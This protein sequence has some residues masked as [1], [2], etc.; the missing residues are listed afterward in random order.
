MPWVKQFD[1]D[2]ALNRAMEAFWAN[3]YEATSL[4]TL[5]RRMNINKGSFYDTYGDKRSLFLAALRS[6][7]VNVRRV[8]LARLERTCTP[9]E[10]ICRLFRGLADAALADRNRSGC[11]LVNTALELAAHDDE[12]GELVAE[13]QRDLEQFFQRRLQQGRASG[14]IPLQ[15]EVQ[16]T[17]RALLSQLLGLLVLARSRPEAPLL[18]AIAADVAAR[19]GEGAGTSG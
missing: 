9:R 2:A 4:Q 19:L 16:H 12:I 1:V 11:L 8:R 17:A 7:D 10:S 3:G 6:Y 15:V 5:L 13:S 18:K 14:E